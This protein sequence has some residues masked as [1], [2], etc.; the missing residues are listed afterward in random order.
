MQVEKIRSV[1][2][3]TPQNAE[4]VTD[5]PS[6]ANSRRCLLYSISAFFASDSR[7]N[8][9][10]IS[11]PFPNCGGS[12][13]ASVSLA[14]NT[15]TSIS[16]TALISEEGSLEDGSSMDNSAYEVVVAKDRSVAPCPT[17]DFLMMERQL[18]LTCY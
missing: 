6:Q 7:E 10:S 12:V 16:F 14:N 3:L 8:L 2:N 13:G 11:P 4:T 18:F 17:S 9:D 1:Q 15:G 5:P